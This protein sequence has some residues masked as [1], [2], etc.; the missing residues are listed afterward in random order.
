MRAG[1]WAALAAVLVSLV[2]ATAPAG[3]APDPPN[4][5][6]IERPD[7]LWPPYFYED[8]WNTYTHGGFN[9]DW[10][11]H[12]RPV[13]TVKAVVLFVDFPNAQA[14][15]VTQVSPIDYRQPQ[16]YW[17]FLKASVPWFSTASYGRFNLEVTPIYKWYRMPKDSTQWRMDYRSNDP[18]RRLSAEGQGEFTAAAVAAADADVDFSQYDLI[19][20]VPARNQTAIASSPELNNYAHQIVADGNDLGNGDNFGSRHV[21]LGLQ[22]PQ[23]R[24]RPRGQ[25]HRG[26]QRG[27]GRHVPLHGPVGHDGQHLRQRAGL[28]RLEQVEARVAERRRGGLRRLRRGHRAHAERQRAPPDGA[29]KKLVAIRTGQHTTLVAEL[30]AP[31]GVDSIA[32]GNTARYCESG[33]ILLYT[34]DSTLRNGLGVYKVLDAMP[35]STG[36]GCSDETSI[37][38]M[39]RGQMRGPSHFEVPELG[40]DLRPDRHQRRRHA[41]EAQGHPSGHEDRRRAR[42]R[43][44]ALHHHADRLQAQRARGRHVRVGLRRR[45]DRHRRERP[46]HLRHAR[47]LRGQADRRRLDH[48]PDGQRHRAVH[49]HADAERPGHGHRGGER[50]V[51]RAREPGRHLR[52]A[53]RRHRRRAPGR[54]RLTYSSPIATTDTVRACVNAGPARARR[55]HEERSSGSPRRAGTSSGTRPRSRAGRTPARARSRATR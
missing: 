28:H 46:A 5:C 10:V 20:T 6:K 2:V 41:G 26:L 25:P 17:E 27:H 45:H 29:S 7:G 4:A 42:G 12:P 16:P 31:L 47:P 55:R 11:A 3:A 52:G 22:A 43:H 48:D 8:Y 15:N 51:H 19:Y 36:W 33:G 39:G 9:S 21:E 37:S 35:G 38:T 40:R 23:P 49:R 53:A 1:R 54:R 32:G 14:S 24:D 18:A 30:R 13:G 34:V 50:H 44:G